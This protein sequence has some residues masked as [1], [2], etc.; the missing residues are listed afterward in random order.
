MRDYGAARRL[1]EFFFVERIW[2]KSYI[3]NGVPSDS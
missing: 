1:P 2:Q 3:E